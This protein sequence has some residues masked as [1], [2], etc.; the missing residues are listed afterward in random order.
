MQVTITVNGAN[1]DALTSTWRITAADVLLHALPIYHT[2]GLFTA[3][4]TTLGA[5]ARIVFLP[6]FDAAQ[7]IRLLP[8]CNLMMG[9]P[10]FYDKL[11]CVPLLNLAV[12][13]I[14]RFVRSLGQPKILHALRLDGPLGR[15][16]LAHM[17]AWAVFFALMTGVGAVFNTAGVRPAG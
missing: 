15:G 10:T 7:V 5:G 6:R 1:A 8:R 14:D 16:N 2:H 9:V 11:L 13:A 3:L 17:G 12:P 4:N